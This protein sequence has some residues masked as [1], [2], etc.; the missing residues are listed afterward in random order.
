MQTIIF[1]PV[2]PL[3]PFGPPIT[4]LPVGFTYIFVFLLIVALFSIKVVRQAEVYIIERLGKY[5]KTWGTGIH[6]LVPFIDRVAVENTCK[7]S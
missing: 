3:S 4:N 5:C 2:K 1:L 7:T 6:M